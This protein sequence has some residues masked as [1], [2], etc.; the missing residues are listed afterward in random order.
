MLHRVQGLGISGS[1]GYKIENGRLPKMCCLISVR[2]G[3]SVNTARNIWGAQKETMMWT[4]CLMRGL[5]DPTLY[6][7]V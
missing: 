1:S 3:P 5:T 7:E 4:F 6:R 2:F